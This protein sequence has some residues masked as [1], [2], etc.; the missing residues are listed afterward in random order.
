MSAP[1]AGSARIFF[2][3]LVSATATAA[4]TA[5]ATALASSAVSPPSESGRL[6]LYGRF[7]FI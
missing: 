1:K 2:L 7:G 5:T 3:R 6:C 4:A